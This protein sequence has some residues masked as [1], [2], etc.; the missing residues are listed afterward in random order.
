MFGRLVAAVD[1]S[2]MSLKALHRAIDLAE[3]LGAELDVVSVVEDLP[4]VY[5]AERSELDAERSAV[6]RYYERLHDQARAEATRRGVEITSRIL[7]GHEVQA[8]IDYTRAQAADLLV[9]GA[10]GHSAVWGAFLGSTADKLVTHAPTSVLVVR[11]EDTGRSFK[12]LVVGLDGSPLG[13]RAFGTALDLC[14]ALNGTLRA[15]SVVEDAASR[16]KTAADLEAHYLRGVQERARAAAEAAG[17]SMEVEMREGHAAGAIIAFAEEVAADLIVIGAT[18]QQRPWSLTAGGTA[19]RIA[20]EARRSALVVR[21]IEPQRVDDVMVRHV[22]TVTPDTPLQTVIDRLIRR[23]VK[24][25]PVVD[26]QLHVVGII[27]GGDLLERGGLGVRLPLMQSVEAHELAAA[28]FQPAQTGLT[29]Q[30]VMTRHPRTVREGTPLAEAI[31]ELVSAKVKRLPVV[32]Q[33]GRLVGIVSRADI[34]RASAAAPP[35]VVPKPSSEPAAKTVGEVMNRNVTTVRPDASAEG[36]LDALLRSAYRR[37]VVVDAE[38][39]VLG[40]ISDRRLLAHADAESRPGVLARLAGLTPAAKPAEHTPLTADRL[41]EG[42][43]FT[44]SSD[45][46]VAEAARQFIARRV[47]R[48]VVVDRENRLEGILDRRALLESLSAALPEDEV[49]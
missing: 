19:R 45:A 3:S 18:G 41:M 37:I 32:D 28:L 26:D 40:M 44:I 34:L 6:Q 42:A 23:R 49:T 39:H 16:S 27:T 29:A 11:P 24:A 17:V 9:L 8:L 15:L 33:N 43:V 20:N 22:T 35:Q 5:V 30:H 36:V 31:H 38:R 47:K 2:E 7:D 46:S 1:G 12:E 10:R 13:E 21:P 25:L 14:R 48:L 4:P